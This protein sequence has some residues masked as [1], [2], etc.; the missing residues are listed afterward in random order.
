MCEAAHRTV[1]LY[2]PVQLDSVL[3][4]DRI[5][6]PH[7]S[8]MPINDKFGEIKRLTSDPTIPVS[9]IAERYKVSRTTMYKVAP[10]QRRIGY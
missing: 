3:K 5:R 1:Y 4:W 10:Q 7:D 6:A 2:T 8:G 9:Q